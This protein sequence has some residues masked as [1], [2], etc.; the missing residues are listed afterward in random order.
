MN[1][2]NY[3]RYVLAC[4][5]TVFSVVIVAAFPFSCR[6]TEDGLKIVSSDSNVPKIVSFS[7]DGNSRL[8]LSCSQKVTVSD[9]SVKSSDGTYSADT[10]LGYEDEGR[11][12]CV[13]LSEPTK[14]GES[15]EFSGVIT[16]ERG[17]SLTFSLP[18]TGFNSNPARLLLTEVRSKHSSS[19]G[20]IKKSEFVELYVLKGGNLASL[21]IVTGSDGEDKKYVFPSIDVRSGEYI[22]VHFRTVSGGG[23]ADELGSNLK[24]STGKDSSGARD[25]WIENTES[26]ISDNDVIVVRDSC[27][28]LVVDAL[29]YSASSKTGWYYKG[30]KALSEQAYESG[31]WQGGSGVDAAAV[32]DG[33]SLTRTMSRLNVDKI[34]KSN[35]EKSLG[36][37]T[38]ITASKNDWAVVK[39]ATPGEKN[40]SEI[41]TK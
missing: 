9:A 12:V 27:R 20:E 40:S 28:G 29:L 26:R 38:V 3:L 6:L 34:I 13:N 2:K 22:V 4:F 8:V 1:I 17:N 35:P 31:V 39:K 24:L 15:Y 21:E 11:L 36:E 33:I 25:L 16:D 18:F 41:Y 37:S 7:A 10:D 5:L 23:C 19:S 30:Q 14:A 32:S